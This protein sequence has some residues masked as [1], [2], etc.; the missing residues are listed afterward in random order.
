[1]ITSP[2]FLLHGIQ[3]LGGNIN[4]VDSYVQGREYLYFM[5]NSFPGI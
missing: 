2:G 5:N 4:Y 3:L 1:M